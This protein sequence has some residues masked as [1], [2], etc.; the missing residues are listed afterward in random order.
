M[1][2]GEPRKLW[3]LHLKF[4]KWKEKELLNTYI[5]NQKVQNPNLDN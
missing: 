3:P 1:A 5:Q 2:G 4:K